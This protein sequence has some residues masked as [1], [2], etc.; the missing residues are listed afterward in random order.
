[1][2]WHS[3]NAS[4]KIGCI[5]SNI[6]LICTPN[7]F[8]NCFISMNALEK[9]LLEL[10]PGLFSKLEETKREV[11]LLLGKYSSNFP[12]YTDHSLQHTLEVY[13]IASEV[14]SDDEL[15]LLNSDEIYVLSMACL[16]HDIGMCIPEEKIQNIAASDEILSY[17]ET[18]PDQN[19]EEFIRNIHHV[20]SNRFIQDECEQLSI[21]TNKYAVAIGIVAEGHRKVD[22]G[23]FEI[24]DPRFFV[25]SGKESVCLPYLSTIL[26]IA[27]ELD[28]T[29]SRTPKLLTKYYM[30]NNEQS[31]REWKKHISTSQRNYSENEVIFEVDCSDQ[32]IY[33]ALQDQFDK[34]QSVINYCQKI[35][36]AIPLFGG[37]QFKL[38]LSKVRIKY[39]F[40]GFD[41]K[42]IKFSFD[43]QNVV[44][45]FI[46]E[47][48]YK[49]R[50][51]SLREAIQ[52]AI[53]SCRYKTKVL[54]EVY[55]PFIK[56]T[57]KEESITIEDNA[58]GMDE[59]I[60]ENFFGR[61]GSSFYEQDKVKNQF[62]AIGQFGVG[63]FSYFLM[64]EY[65]D[66]ETK[67]PNGKALKFRFDKDP[68]SYFHFY[69]K[70][71]RAEP[72]TTIT[73][74]L[75]KGFENIATNEIEG[76]LRKTFKHVEIPIELNILGSRS[77][78]KFESF[79]PF[80]IKDIREKIKLQY[81]KEIDL[82]QVTNV[83]INDDELEGICYLVIGKKISKVFGD[84][85]KF[86]DHSHLTTV[87]SGYSSSQ[88]SVS[89]KGV[90]VNYYEAPNLNLLFGQI[91]LKRKTKINIDRNSFTD[92]REIE[93]YIERFE[94]K[95]LNEVFNSVNTKNINKEQQ[96]EITKNFLNN[97][98]NLNSLSVLTKNTYLTLL[99]EYLFVSVFNKKQ[100]KIV[101]L[102][103]FVS[104][105]DEFI[106][107][108]DEEDEKL[109]SK[110]IDKPIVMAQK[111][112]YMG[113]YNE[114]VSIFEN[115]G[116]FK[117]ILDHGNSGYLLCSKKEQAKKLEFE[118]HENIF[119]GV[120]LI[121][122]NSKKILVDVWKNKP[123][124]ENIHFDDEFYFNSEHPFIRFIEDHKNLILANIDYKRIVRAAIIFISDLY[125]D[126][127]ISLDNIKKINE[128]I[129]PL[130]EIANFELLKI[131]DF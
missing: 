10:D 28:V 70:T 23:N 108:V 122:S 121:G 96:F 3:K 35:I 2:R 81:R 43:V 67:V 9:K 16:L 7:P 62:E 71:E 124:L 40:I 130:K 69:A 74:Y 34:I 92:Q 116:Y 54:K 88:I 49:D 127:S 107:I 21:P 47:E 12:T 25:K 65:I 102:N 66:I 59:F 38:Q 128:M 105:Y 50:L 104:T 112:L 103:T 15:E 5:F 115:L 85:M 86:F 31:M 33:A 118:L 22:L 129:L 57:V 97:Y 76:Y 55:T 48:L 42:G 98:Y 8:V 111:E 77:I 110:K 93:A 87:N 27:D 95:V 82:L 41:P 36:R 44:T 17:R 19:T 101:L 68:K 14:L 114:F 83:Y 80:S 29:N 20:L 125:S 90:F 89:Q 32:S 73:L 113:A 46:G 119:E 117:Y 58:A 39:N 11:N 56:V 61:L 91:N 52:N 64:A 60:I 26:R 4:I 53:D 84:N 126:E 123:E 18:H 37:R 94:I 45:A 131:S 30:P 51:T 109:V 63:V 99:K 120:P 13:K 24:Y 78:L 6:Y 79:A 72:G 1:M 75:K 106:L 100:T